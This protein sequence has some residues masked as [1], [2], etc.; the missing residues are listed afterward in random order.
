MSK[1]AVSTTLAAIAVVALLVGV[2]VGVAL[3]PSLGVQKT[4]EVQ[5][6]VSPLQGELLIGAILPL[7]GA[8]GSYG[9]NSNQAVLLAE[10]EVNAFLQKAG[11][12]FT[13]KV[14]VEDTQTK[15]DVALQKLQSL[16]ARG[17]KLFVGPQTSGE[18]R[19]I[20]SYADANKLLLVSQS[21][22]APDLAIAGDFIYRFCPDDTIQGPIGPRLFN[23]LG[24]THM[25]YVYRGDAWGDGLFRAS[26]AE[27]Q[28]LGLTVA[29]QI[30][31]APEKGEFSAEAKALSDSVKDL[32]AKGIGADKIGIEFVAFAEAVG[33]MVA[34]VDYPELAKVKWF[35][36]D[37]TA[38]LAELTKDPK[39]AKFA[40][41]IKWVNP[42][43]APSSNEKFQRVTDYVKQKLGRAPDSYAYSAYDIVWVLT[44]A[45]LQAQK[46]DGEA[47]RT[48]LSDVANNYYGA[49][50]WTKLNP[51]GDLASA[52]Y[53]LWI[54]APKAGGY[55]WVAA[56]TYSFATGSFVWTPGFTP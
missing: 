36:S 33:F 26:T 30:R 42:I 15:P 18:V 16:A 3:A 56:G 25:V 45:M 34:A 47:V 13:I 24:I 10:S 53:I 52:D 4:V 2:A 44:L 31:Y 27:A 9:E 22:T 20:K 41:S 40:S 1:K 21:S 8:L 54:V 29:Q 7:T 55:D 37:G 12:S 5:V 14:L 50:G 32:L 11:Q 6:P 28:K 19:Q 35:G 46:Y 48:V 39:A 49:I 38:Q 23:S 17:V 43:F 51:G